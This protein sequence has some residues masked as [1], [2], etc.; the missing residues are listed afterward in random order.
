LLE[1]EIIHVT[2]DKCW[3]FEISAE[4]F[5]QNLEKSTITQNFWTY[6]SGKWDALG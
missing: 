1:A 4:T 5:N 6:K 3:L 2:C